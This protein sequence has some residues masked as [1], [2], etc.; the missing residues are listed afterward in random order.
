MLKL[1]QR[2]EEPRKN[3]DK[4]L[5]LR[6]FQRQHCVY[7]YTSINQTANTWAD[8]MRITETLTVNLRCVHSD[9]RNARLGRSSGCS[10]QCTQLHF[11]HDDLIIFG[12]TNN[13]IVYIRSLDNS[14][15]MLVFTAA[16]GSERPCAA[17][18]QNKWW[19]TPNDIP[20]F[21]SIPVPSCGS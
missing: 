9:D 7:A 11:Q 20:S 14:F 5:P 12:H 21:G 15:T 4:S 8:T 16:R 1:R 6:T 17:S 13:N 10:D 19:I 3:H 18:I 2:R